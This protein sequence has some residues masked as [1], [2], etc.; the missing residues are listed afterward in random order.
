MTDCNAVTPP[1]IEI[2]NCVN[3]FHNPLGIFG[4]NSICLI[5]KGL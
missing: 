4:E 2:K 3:I 1:L 5:F